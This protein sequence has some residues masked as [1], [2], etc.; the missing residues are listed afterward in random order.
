MSSARSLWLVAARRAFP[1]A[2]YLAYALQQ[3][4]KP[5]HWLNGLGH[6]QQGEM[7]AMSGHDVLIAVSFD[8]YAHET[9]E[10]VQAARA[11]GAKLI[12]LT[13][14]QFSPLAK[15]AAVTLLAA[16]S[17]PYGFRSLTATLSLAQALFIS[18]AWRLELAAGDQGTP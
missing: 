3:T 6:M 5:V 15:D 13:D 11:R 8:P 17:A 2:A 18:L 14:S 16:D 1:I 4:D 10:V 9:L 12:A 7:R